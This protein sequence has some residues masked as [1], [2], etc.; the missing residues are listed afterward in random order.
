[1]PEAAGVDQLQ[2]ALAVF[3]LA[4]AEN[5]DVSGNDGIVEHIGGQA[6]D[7]FHEVVLQ[8]TVADFAFTGTG[9]DG[10]QRR[11]VEDNAK[12]AA[13]VMGRTHL[14]DQMQ[15]KQQRTVGYTRQVGAEAA[16]VTLAPVF[17]A[18]VLFDLFPFRTERRIGQHIVIFD[19][20]Q[21]D[22]RCPE[23]LPKNPEYRRTSFS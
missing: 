15:Q 22:R 19:E 12:A 21:V 7:G 8:H 2:L 13:A 3:R 11:A 17:L 18:D 14:A 16:V 5:P 9:R 20:Q 1:M 4:V 23:P 6:D 10:K